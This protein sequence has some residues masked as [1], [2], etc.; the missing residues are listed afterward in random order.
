MLSCAFS[1][2]NPHLLSPKAV[3][4][5]CWQLNSF[6]SFKIPDRIDDLPRRN[7]KS[8][9]PKQLGCWR[10]PGKP[11]TLLFLPPHFGFFMSPW[12]TFSEPAPLTLF[13]PDLDASSAI[14]LHSLTAFSPSLVFPLLASLILCSMK[15]HIAL[16][17]VNL[18]AWS[19][20]ETLSWWRAPS[21]PQ[22]SNPPQTC[23]SSG[24]SNSFQNNFYFSSTKGCLVEPE[25]FRHH[26]LHLPICINNTLQVVCCLN[27]LPIHLNP[28]HVPRMSACLLHFPHLMH[29]NVPHKSLPF[30]GLCL[31]RSFFLRKTA[32]I[33]FFRHRIAWW[34]RLW[35][36]TFT[37]PPRACL[38]WLMHLP[39]QFPPQQNPAF[40]SWL[41]S[42]SL[43]G[44]PSCVSHPD[45][46]SFLRTPSATPSFFFNANP[47]LFAV[48]QHIL[49]PCSTTHESYHI[50]SLGGWKAQSSL[51]APW[52]K[53][54]TLL[55]WSCSATYI[56]ANIV[57]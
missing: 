44:V 19:A 30:S 28:R 7:E 6:T 29:L 8:I 16:C 13:H 5:C 27:A 38:P 39:F 4:W 45:P 14:A 37:V 3:Q 33:F 57:P 49:L 41:S 12:L 52:W 24:F 23:P 15:C 11:P 46:G 53:P 36:L 42:P 40:W 21:F 54:I 9:F 2:E 18:Q 32:T 17:A 31:L 56:S 10:N 34:S 50:G 47:N 22:V 48:V 55:F 25:P 1:T 51:Q 43:F 35:P 26:V 20:F